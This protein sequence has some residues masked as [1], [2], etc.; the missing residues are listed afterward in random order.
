MAV[1]Q[2]ALVCGCE[3]IALRTIT[4]GLEARLCIVNKDL[5]LGLED[6]QF[7]TID[8]PFALTLFYLP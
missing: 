2:E 6:Y 5:L 1:C 4:F 3:C 7:T 8:G